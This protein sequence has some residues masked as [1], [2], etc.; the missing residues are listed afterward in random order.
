MVS[1][2]GAFA[3]ADAAIRTGTGNINVF[4]PSDA[5]VRLRAKT[6][7]NLCDRLLDD[8]KLSDGVESALAEISLNLR[9]DN[10]DVVIQGR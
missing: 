3:N 6:R 4:V 2:R 7:G 8:C 10:G 9:S 1:I 5:T